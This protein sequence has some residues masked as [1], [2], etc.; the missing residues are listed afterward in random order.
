MRLSERLDEE[1]TVQEL[2]YRLLD[3]LPGKLAQQERQREEAQKLFQ[4]IAAVPVDQQVKM[5]RRARFRSLSF[6][7]Y[8]LEE[9]HASQPEN[10]LRAED[11]AHLAACLAGVLADTEPEAGPALPHAL[12]LGANARRLG[13]D[14]AGADALLERAA[15]FLEFPS[16]RA[17]YCRYAGLIRW[18]QG[19]ADEAAALLSHAGRLY[20]SDG[21]SGEHGICRALLGLLCQEEPSLGDCRAPLEEG[22]ACL[23]LDDHPLLG[24]RVCLGLAA[25]LSDWGKADRARALLQEAWR[26]YEK[27]S[28]EREMLR[29]YWLEARVL[30]RLDQKAE[31]LAMLESVRRKLVAEPNPGEAALI[32]LD[33]ALTMMKSGRAAEVE[34]LAQALITAFPD[35]PTML[36]AT[37]NLSN[38]ADLAALD[39]IGELGERSGIT[40]RRTFRLRGLRIRPF[41]FA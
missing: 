25:C 11:L 17:M 20:R 27:V 12:C 9:S 24:L 37:G 7:D 18:E 32:S 5:L 8:L 33:L 15:P 2:P 34:G 36:L 21:L 26:L 3:L 14:R 16:E 31:A 6:L 35:E 30:A 19:R 1:E 22:W 40:L 29:I 4:E 41:P 23:K 13:N 10:P 28:N 38:L 39:Q